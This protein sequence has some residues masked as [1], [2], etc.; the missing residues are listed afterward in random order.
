MTQDRDGFSLLQVPVGWI[1]IVAD[2]R[3]IKEVF[4]TT[5][6]EQ[7]RTEILRKYP[8][9]RP[10]GEG[11]AARGCAQVADYFLGQRIRFDLELDWSACSDF[12][13]KVLATLAEVRRGETLTYGELARM[14]GY[15]GRARGVGQVMA[16]NPFPLIIP[17]HRV[18]GSDGRMTGYSGA[19][20][21]ETKRWLLDFEKK[22][23]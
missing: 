9:A 12:A 23:G 19:N 3:A 4:L 16:R 22:F 7:L 21:V 15:P 17:C 6:Q 20:G 14:A 2:R 5:T 1:G 10:V 8:T 18:V 13:R 11:P